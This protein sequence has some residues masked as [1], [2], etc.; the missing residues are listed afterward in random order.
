MDKGDRIVA[1]VIDFS[2]A[3]Q[4]VLHDRLLIENCDLGRGFE[5]IST[6][7]GVVV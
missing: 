1:I 7:K 5:G 3:F 4:L 2:K 6:G